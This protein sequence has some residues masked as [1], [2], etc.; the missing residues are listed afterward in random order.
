[1]KTEVHF[2]R[3]LMAGSTNFDNHKPTFK[4][5][6]LPKF[7]RD[8]QN[9]ASEPNL[10]TTTGNSEVHVFVK[11]PNNLVNLIGI[12]NSQNLKDLAPRAVQQQKRHVT[13]SKRTHRFGYENLKKSTQKR[14][15][16]ENPMKKLPRK[17]IMV[18]R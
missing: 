16:Q 6:P 13:K 4:K 11:K 9:E 12:E 1:M 10:I 5:K 2:R 18:K 3:S 7:D 15:Q 8:I 17:Q 14:Q